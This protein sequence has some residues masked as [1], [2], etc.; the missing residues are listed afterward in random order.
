MIN[1]KLFKLK[2]FLIEYFTNMGGI[3]RSWDT[4]VNTLTLEVL[5]I[6]ENMVNLGFY[7]SD[8]ELIQIL[9]PVIDLLDGS[10][11][12]TSPQEEEEFHHYLKKTK[13]YEEIKAAGGKLPDYPELKKDKE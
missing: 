5:S 11:D 7:Q 8:E 4:E 13:E 1:V 6:F 3:M 9:N 12:Y 2:D 10:N